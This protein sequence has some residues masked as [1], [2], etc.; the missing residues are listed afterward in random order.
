MRCEKEV[1]PAD[2]W[3]SRKCFRDAI[4]GG[5]FCKQHLPDAM[6]RREKSRKEKDDLRYKQRLMETRGPSAIRCMKR[7]HEELE[8]GNAMIAKVMLQK[9]LQD[10]NQH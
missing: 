7:A 5:K 9:W 8:K 10:H 1:Y 3:R 4:E 6:D 2:G